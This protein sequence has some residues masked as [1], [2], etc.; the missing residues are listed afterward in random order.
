MAHMKKAKKT[1]LPTEQVTQTAQHVGEVYKRKGPKQQVKKT[2]PARKQIPEIESVFYCSKCPSTF[3]QRKN[4]LSHFRNFHGPVLLHYICPKCGT[5]FS[6]HYLL[7]Y[8]LEEKHKIKVQ[9]AKKFAVKM[10]GK[11]GKM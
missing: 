10:R 11:K 2:L 4:L 9:N 6:S 3:K 8:H 1:T 7:K 5:S